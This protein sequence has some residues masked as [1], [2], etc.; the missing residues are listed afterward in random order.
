MAHYI[1]DPIP[2]EERKV[3]YMMIWP[4]RTWIRRCLD[5]RV[6]LLA[7]CQNMPSTEDL[8]Q[9]FLE[10]DR[11]DCSVQLEN[12]IEIFHAKRHWARMEGW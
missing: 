12:Q 6:H 7:C 11:A 4:F 2:T 5:H 3:F 8:P 1:H 9:T 10:R